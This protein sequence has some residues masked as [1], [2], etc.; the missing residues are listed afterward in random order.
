[1]LSSAQLQEAFDKYDKDKSGFLDMDEVVKLAS[2]LGAKA[3][4]KELEDLF[5]SIDSDHDNK[6]SFNEFLAWYRVG[7]HSKL[8]N[9]LKYQMQLE[10][11]A[12]AFGGALTGDDSSDG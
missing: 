1:M 2:S 6:L 7:K 9:L 3:S 8:A 5:K 4:K 11:G 10:K 12:K